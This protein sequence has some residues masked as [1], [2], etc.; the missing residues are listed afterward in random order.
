MLQLIALRKKKKILFRLLSRWSRCGASTP[1][2]PKESFGSSRT[3][4]PNKYWKYVKEKSGT[5]YLLRC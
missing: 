2:E 4:P 1:Y 3:K 5:L